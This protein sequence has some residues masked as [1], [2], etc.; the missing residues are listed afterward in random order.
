MNIPKLYIEII[1]N[2]KSTHMKIIQYSN[3]AYYFWCHGGTYIWLSK[4]GN[5][6][7]DPFS[8]NMVPLMF[9]YIPT[10][11]L[12]SLYKYTYQREVCGYRVKK[13]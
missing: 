2:K 5:I 4:T 8:L 11:P 13:I 10:K 12:A 9:G 1:E 7:K 3:H 6:F